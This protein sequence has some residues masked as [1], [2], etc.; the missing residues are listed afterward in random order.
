MEKEVIVLESGFFVDGIGLVPRVKGLVRDN[1]KR[2]CR[3]DV[4]PNNDNDAKREV[5]YDS[6]YGSAGAAY[7]A[8]MNYLYA[9]GPLL[10]PRTV[11]HLK[12]RA[13][14]KYKVGVPGVCVNER[15]CGSN[16]YY[17]VHVGKMAEVPA[18][19][20]YVGKLDKDS[21]PLQDAILLAKRE[22]QVTVTKYRRKRKVKLADV[23]P[24]AVKGL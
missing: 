17:S 1:Q 18:V 10:A 21:T 3:W 7:I 24:W 5:F 4:R 20:F 23:M 8:A 2:L 6:A 12:E 15:V 14:K 16:T 11:T 19:Y 22:R 9:H 13:T